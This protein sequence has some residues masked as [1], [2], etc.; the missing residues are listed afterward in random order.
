M[1]SVS[2][3]RKKLIEQYSGKSSKKKDD[4]EEK[5][6]NISNTNTSST[7]TTKPYKKSAYREELLKK[8]TTDKIKST[9]VDKWFDNV[10]SVFKDMEA[11]NTQD[12]SG[13]IKNL[14]NS[15]K[16][17]Y[18][19][20]QN[21]K[22]YLEDF[23][24]WDKAFSQNRSALR[25]VD[26]WYYDKNYELNKIDNMSVDEIRAKIEASET[27]GDVL[28]NAIK[29]LET[30]KKGTPDKELEKD[31][32]Y[33]VKKYGLDPDTVKESD[34]LRIYTNVG[35]DLKPVDLDVE[36]PESSIAYYEPDGTAVSW[37]NLLRI[38]STE[39]RMSKMESS[40]E[41]KAAY[42]ELVEYRD[43]I[44]RL[45]N[46]QFAISAKAEGIAPDSEYEKDLEYAIEKYG[47]DPTLDMK[48]PIYEI[49]MQLV[50]GSY[51][52][53]EDQKAV[54][55][56]AGYDW[57]EFEAYKKYFEDKEREKE[58]QKSYRKFA[59]DYPVLSTVFS[60]ASAPGQIWDYAK[61]LVYMA[62]NSD[63][64]DD[65]F[66]G[67]T[68]VYDNGATN[69][70]GTITSTVANK[71]DKEVTESTGQEWVGWLASSAY[72]GGTSALQSALT[73]T[74]CVGLFGPTGST[75]SLGLQGSQAAASSFSS[76][77]KNGSTN[78]EALATS[79]ASGVAEGLFEKISL[80]HFLKIS[81]GYD[82]TTLSG[83][84]KSI[85]KDSKNLVLQGLVESSEEMFTEMANNLADDIINGDHS[86]YN[87]AVAQYKSKG[88]PEEE[89]KKMAT[90]DYATNVLSA[91]VGGFIGGVSSGGVAVGTNAIKGTGA[92]INYQNETVKPHG[93]ALIKQGSKD[94]LM[95]F[96][97]ETAKT[98]SNL[99]KYIDK[100]TKK[101]SAK[102]VG[103]L[104]LKVEQSL[105]KQNL[106]DITKHFENKGIETKDAQKFAGYVNKLLEG[107]ALTQE[108]KAELRKLKVG[109]AQIKSALADI[110]SDPES[111]INIREAD[112]M[113]ARM[114]YKGKVTDELTKSST[115]KVTE[116][117]DAIESGDIAVSEDGKA[118]I[119]SS[120]ETVTI[121]KNNAIARIENVDGNTV[122]YYNTSKGEVEASDIS[123]AS[124]SDALL[125]EAFTDLSP[126]VASSLIRNYANIKNNPVPVDAYVEGMR[127]GILFYGKYGFRE[128]G[129]DILEGSAFAK[130]PK[131]YQSAALN[132]GREVSKN[133]TKTK[134]D[135]I[136]SG[137]TKAN[138]N[139]KGRVY[140]ENGAKAGNSS[141][142]RAV[143]L[144]K[145]IASAIGINIAFY[146]ST[147][148]GTVNSDANGWFDRET[149]TI[150]LDL[151]KAVSDKHTI[152]FTLS[153]EIVHFIEKWSPE[154]YKVLADFL[155]TQYAKHGVKTEVLLQNKMAALGTTDVD[156]AYREMVAD[157]MESMLLD[158]NATV[159]L[160]ELRQKDAGLFNK[161]KAHILDL[162][163]KIRNEYK[164]RGYEPTSEEGKA[165]RAMEDSLTQFHKLFEEALVGAT[166]SY[167]NAEVLNTESVSIS[168][169]GTVQLQMKQYEQTG[170][171]TLL[172]YLKQQYGESDANDLI[173]TIDNIYNAM[174]ELKQDTALSVFG[175][176]Q[177][178]EVE[179]DANG[180]PIFTTSINNGDYELNQDF[181]RV[182]KK[183]R[184]LD[185]VLNML[186]EDPAFEASNLTKED[187]VKIN[188]A[189]KSHG[190]EIACAL[191]FVDSKRFRQAEW[192]DS[193][194]NTWNDILNS[195][196]SSDKALSRFNFATANPNMNDDGI[197]IDTSKPISFRKWSD[198]KAKETR[199][200]KNLD[201]LLENEGNA[202]VR[203]IAKL[204]RDN[205][206]LRH[207][208]RGADIIASRGFDSLQRLAPDV[209]GILDG[210]GGTSVPKPSSNDA[211]YDNSVLNIAGYNA[212][213]AFA[214]GGV[215]MN[216]F[217]DFM[218]HMFF[219]YA[220]AFADL[221]AKKLPMHSYTKELDFARLFGLSGGKI[222]MSAIA[223]IRSN[224][225]DISKIKDKAQK[226]AATEREKSIAG[227]DISRLAG[228]LGKNES[229]ITYDDVIQNL[230]DVDYVW[231]DESID[232][233]S[234]TL[235]QS[236]ILYDK[237]TEGQAS[238]CY[239]LIREGKFEEAFKVAG[240]ENVNKAYAKHL[241]IITVGVSKAHILKL[242]RDPT[243][244][245]VIPYHKSGLNATIAKALKIAFYNDYTD[246][247]NTMF[248]KN[249]EAV[250]LSKDGA[251]VNG[252]KIREFSFYDYFGKTIDGVFYDG[253]ATADKYLDW[254]RNG[255]Y[256]ESVG[257][258]VYYL[259]NGDYILASELHAQGIEII[260]KFNEFSAE[261]NYYKLI[262]DFDCYDTITGE[263][264]QQEAVDIFH[265]GLPSDYKKVLAEALKTEQQVSDDFKDHLDNKG[266]R[267]E[268]MKIVKARGYTPSVDRVQKQ[269]KTTTG[270]IYDYSKSFA[271]QVDDYKRG[272]IP[273]RDS[274]L[275]SGTP[276]I[277]QKIGFNALPVTINQT[278]VDY[279][280]NGTKD[281]DHHIGEMLLKALPNAI[282]SPVAIIQSQSP[283]SSDRAVVILKTK[284]NGK[285]VISA[286]EVDGQGLS[287]NIRIDSNAMTTL[288][289]KGNSL[290]QLNKAINNTVN[291]G[292]ELF[293][294]NKKETITLL[295]SAGL[296]L[297][298]S[299]PRDGFVHSITDI[300]SKVKS[301]F[302]NVTETQQFKR[303]FGDWKNNPKK[304]SKVVNDDGTPMIV[305]HGS[306][307]RDIT[308]FQTANANGTGGLYLS[309]NR[310]VAETF[311]GDG[312]KVYESYVNL[313]K[314]LIIDAGGAYYDSIATPLEMVGSN[315]A[316]GGDTVD[317][318][319]IAA[320]ARNAG[321]DGVIVKNVREVSGFGDDIIAFEPNQ[322]KSATHNIGTFNSDS[323]NI[324]YQ[325]KH[326]TEATRGVYINDS[327]QPFTEQILNGEKTI[328]TREQ[329]KNRQYPELHKFIGERIGIVRSG[330]GK[331]MLVGFATVADE[332][333]YNTE[334][335]FR[336]DESKHLVKKGSAYDIK[337]K[338]YGYVLTDVERVTPW[339]IP[340]GSKRNG[341]SDVDITTYH[342]NQPLFQKKTTSNRELLANA[343]E[344]TVQNHIERNKLVQ[345][346]EKI[347]LINAE[348]Q[349]LRELRVQI[350]DISFAKGVR[351]T[352]RL[353]ELQTEA[354]KTANR[355]STY[356][357]QLLN[358][359]STKALKNVLERE[360][361][362]AYQKA[363]KKGK[364][365]L[366][367]YREKSAATVR[368]ILN[369]NQEARE[370]RKSSEIRDK[371]KKF[372][373]K[374][375]RSLLNPTDRV[376]V[377]INLAN[378]MIGV[379]DL[380]DTDTPLYKAN[381]TINKAQVRRNLTKDRLQAL[382]DEY[383]ALKDNADPTYS[384]EFDE[385]IYKYLTKLRNEFGDKSLADM[386]YEELSEMYDVLKSI[387]GTLQDARKLIGRTD[388][389][390]IYDAADSI[391]SEQAKITKKRK[392][393]KRN[394]AQRAKDN[395]IDLS[396]SPVRNV[397]RMSGY[398]QN[399]EL[400]KLF[401][402][403]EKGVRQK[404][405]FVM[406][407]YKAFEELTTGDNSKA[408]EDAIYKE[409]GDKKYIDV[410]GRKFGISK[411]Q[412]MQTILSYEREVANR[413]HH[414]EGSGF[415]FADMDMLRKGKLK[416]A[417]S[418]E[419]S[420]RLPAAVA[421]VEEFK[422]ALEN[423]K[424][425]QDY[426]EASRKFFNG[427]AKDAINE[428][429]LTLKHRIIARDKSY[430]PFEVDK[431][432]VV[433]EISAQNDIQQTINSYGMLQETK[434]G[435]SQPLIIT[436]LNNIL[437]RHIDQVG[438][439]YGL[440]VPVRNFNKVWNVRSTESDF[441]D[442]S[443]QA[444]IQRNWGLGGTKHITQTVQDLQGSRPNSQY[445]IYRKIKSGYIGATFLL[446]LSVVTKQIGSLYAATSMLK[447]RGGF[448]MFANLVGTMANSKKISAE[449]D[450]YTATA[451]M[452]RQGLSD[453]ELYTLVT[454]S[455]KPGLLKFFSKFPTV[456]NPSKWITAMD[457]A[458]AL[459]LWKY[460]KQ[461]TAK[462]TG[463]K[464]EELLKATA[465][466]YDSVIENT[467][468][469]T[470]VLHRPEIQKRSD[471]VSEAF[472]MFK[473]DLYQMAG[474]LQLSLGRFNAN[475][476]AE[477]CKVLGR[478]VYAILRSAIWGSLMTTLFALLR[479]KV[480]PYR[481]E[482]DKD[483]N[484]WSWMKRLLFG[485]GGDV[486]G[487]FLPLAGSEIVGVF[488]NI[489]YGESEDIVDSL[490]LTAINDLYDA[491]I[492][493]GSAV[494]DGEM[495]SA[496]Q[497]TKLAVKALQVFGVPSNNIK[498]MV[499]A[500][501]LHAKDI[502]S[503][504]P[505][506]F[507]AGAERTSSNYM[508]GIVEEV[509]AGNTD[510]AE[511][512][513]DKAV[514]DKGDAELRTALGDMYK[515]GEVD[516]DTVK[517]I[518]SEYFEMDDNEIYWK[519]DEWDFAKENDSSEDYAKYDDF[520]SAVESGKNLKAVIKRY[521][522]NGVEKKTLSS[523]I[524]KYFKPLYI[525]M[526][527]SERANLKGYLLNA[528]V[529]LGYNR[530]EKSKDIDKWLED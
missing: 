352:K 191:C 171:S 13:R 219:D 85:A 270:S 51:S 367:A 271:E 339:Q 370:R 519:L 66:R 524:T 267:D 116:T 185:F 383:E 250:G 276:K 261:E 455:K 468:S 447:W 371:I 180:H 388:A 167:Q 79:I 467:Q 184:Q 264:S 229:D 433:R 403:F 104:S 372:K 401:N 445:D 289:A 487:Y 415:A 139:G 181:S 318:N 408:Y 90:I 29:A 482:D 500:I 422:S 196:M 399:S 7:E 498:R 155:M 14:L 311:A 186:A 291:G 366:A 307:S 83:L 194:A 479:Y 489:M 130:L 48:Q 427:T 434:Q 107:E 213:K 146:D 442:P 301:K 314:P 91:M 237:L 344:D 50:D 207:E 57:D 241:G 435:A 476:N 102:N 525:E 400:V 357:R 38:K 280:L 355:I 485:L 187:F 182:C 404:N 86:G 322:V 262:E 512:R 315:Y 332:I 254:C 521:V 477:N 407:A 160:M 111:P 509:L 338:K 169:D 45:E 405:F 67:M 528:Y 183:R 475:K 452:R 492:T 123:Y 502:A 208:F 133:E 493:V 72:S 321:Y 336:A 162:I 137:T 117:K 309:T 288:F 74:V 529:Q 255:E 333:V 260:P 197:D 148:S 12:Y 227:L 398:N 125:Y 351:D 242:M 432:F 92:Y 84:F 252:S 259:K 18:N 469:M 118:K 393:G 523:Q 325:K 305:Y 515:E 151:Q 486:V 41:V 124:E 97:R 63:A 368:E 10:S 496:D 158:S 414:I 410:N 517:D 279:A 238:Y 108:D 110:V 513:F 386:T 53:M 302:A 326:N 361:K 145:H 304:A 391:I 73:T 70:T 518:L 377:P 290:D 272:L 456:I 15:S 142:K 78:G 251:K 163:N 488:E 429:Y 34:I 240:E 82:V 129:K 156:L 76:A 409:Y 313:R 26:K 36:T 235:L 210:W 296:Q 20:L 444:A 362:L 19:Y 438:N 430:I 511:K 341:M 174:A 2:E 71:I 303:W 6:S 365:A 113:L 27:V 188:E 358:L 32:D 159:K 306:K 350:K 501:K 198:G 35:E 323:P 120:D 484:I 317:T 140:F 356:D 54:L 474:Q 112:L 121:D 149:D 274:L 17:V 106:S 347:D 478:T 150:H 230:D 471:V 418:E 81:K 16:D 392:N 103:T 211:I 320:F 100:V 284:H 144:A 23:D 199:H 292:V 495:P 9:D 1:S 353:K 216:S 253:K 402:D 278:H 497:Y 285:Q 328:E 453:A 464:G 446:N 450:K 268:I 203:T 374:L 510:E 263:H 459:S 189:I 331:A 225:T 384:G 390:T 56:A 200:Y 132:I 75:I 417:V 37:K 286:I 506:S 122:V 147:I 275:V 369:R 406:Q 88:Y 114:G 234:A 397:E 178:T 77:I 47:L 62:Q 177:D 394:A 109:E 363:E 385:V 46:A 454:E 44:K 457:H 239:E 96:A 205:P 461:D 425:S 437:D 265:D 94:S 98:D 131:Q 80:D 143:S 348:E 195:M 89:A 451:W 411:M 172:N 232:V 343:L 416:E 224:A 31:L 201:D 209:R 68:N 154:K 21:N 462:K 192:A 135:K 119:L 283:N 40:P 152:A 483:L 379:C 204:I 4:E 491:M 214:V 319:A 466:F 308:I 465:E 522:D 327:T 243:I 43:D 161:L 503:G 439:V 520:Y 128:V 60:I 212:K 266:L 249:G 448:R 330:K 153:H 297:P 134:Q 42:D 436:G 324:Y 39:E 126:S 440:A 105:S 11:D 25:N 165:V 5:K 127:E 277:W 115:A 360:K 202:N 310:S 460:A 480:N 508:Y 373:A 166:E 299:L 141:Q 138:Q 359:E 55:E 93:S 269:A 3:Y 218:A 340:Q 223:A 449:V 61:D 30:R 273:I 173:S 526:S 494:K 387:E 316:F 458:V 337:S 95:E 179:L 58:L 215:R 504:Q 245:M 345:Y 431:N 334:A 236:G 170:R 231:A 443:V 378:A 222:N 294:W 364:E 206:K 99:N 282:Q 346:K 157:A 257:D 514:A 24:L 228:K 419:Y 472:G 300:G 233:K 441:G 287:N 256:D 420:H 28:Q 295:Q 507:E 516:V 481:D 175:N 217:S 193:F 421:L 473:T 382:K 426:M 505:F 220:Q 64:A 424:W 101:A 59:E 396:L 246:V 527:R 258:Y 381:G 312:G 247:Q 335:E 428:T 22:D 298:G 380:I 164:N 87:A 354:T 190:F 342:E 52:G 530:N 248:S 33:V 226:E 168:E 281:V 470:D 490:A 499:D 136:N 221:S 395:V 329:P 423:D 49:Y 8:Y 69:F 176:W 376:Y 389:Q 244:R 65:S 293:Y 463:L 412:M 349:K 413:M 375:E